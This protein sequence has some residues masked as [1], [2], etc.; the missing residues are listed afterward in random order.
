LKSRN[1]DV[2]DHDHHAGKKK[3]HMWSAPPGLPPDEWTFI[4]NSITIIARR[5][6]ALALSVS[7]SFLLQNDW[8]EMSNHFVSS[9]L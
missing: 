2:V 3:R 6:H 7:L 9:Y 1:I 8:A 5:A 4:N